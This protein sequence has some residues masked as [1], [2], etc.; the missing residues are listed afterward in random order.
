MFMEATITLSVV[1]L[2]LWAAAIWASYKEDPG[3]KRPTSVEDGF[4]K[5]NRYKKGA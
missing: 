5:K 4:L 1:M 3:T 2:M